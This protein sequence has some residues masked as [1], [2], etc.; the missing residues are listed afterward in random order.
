MA[1]KLLPVSVTADKKSSN[2]T[3]KVCLDA[4]KMSL[5]CNPSQDLRPEIKDEICQLEA[6]KEQ[7]DKEEKAAKDH[8]KKAKEAY[9]EMQKGRG[10]PEDSFAYRLDDAIKE[11]D[12]KMQAWHGG[13]LNG[14]H[15]GL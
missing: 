14:Y 8:K 6:K 2:E 12:G 1:L 4:L 13:Q 15:Q 5:K 7:L 3:D 9:K 10:R 11:A